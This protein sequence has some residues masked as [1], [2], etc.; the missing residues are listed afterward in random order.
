MGTAVSRARGNGILSAV[1]VGAFFGILPA[2]ILLA[3]PL[4]PFRWY[5]FAVL[6]LGAV[7]LVLVFRNNRL[8]H[9]G[10]L[11]FSLCLNLDIHIVTLP[12]VSYQSLYGYVIPLTLFPLI[13]LYIRRI[14]EF[15]ADKERREP[16]KRAMLPLVIFAAFCLFSIF[17]SG[18][19]EHTRYELFALAQSL[20]IYYYLAGNIRNRKEVRVIVYALI[21]GVALQAVLATLQ[22]LTGS[23]LGLGMF[24]ESERQFGE[25]VSLLSITRV[26]GTMG[27]PNSLAIYLEFL[28]PVS[29]AA[30]LTSRAGPKRWLLMGIAAFG[31][32]ALIFTLS[33]AGLLV[34]VFS[35][36]TVLLVWGKRNRRLG[37]VL[38]A[39][40]ACLAIGMAIFSLVENPIKARFFK[41]R[42]QAAYSRLPMMSV[43]FRM[44]EDN[45]LFGVG[46]NTYTWVA[47]RYDFTTE[48]I[49]L[50]FPMPVHNM[51]L[52]MLA[53]IGIF[54]FLAFIVFMIT[55]LTKG[56]KVARAADKEMALIGLGI[57][58]GILA[59]SIHGMVDLN[60]ISKNFTF[61]LLAGTLVGIWNLLRR[62]PVSAGLPNHT[63]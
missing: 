61:W 8:F 52:L 57:T 14:W 44:I 62:K 63:E 22:Y 51:Y 35:L 56:L 60:H 43:A 12:M 36:I 59:F 24:G 23:Y 11:A 53:E 9:I 5:L 1:L 46:L 33:R 50:I 47:P 15:W 38:A 7:A 31:V 3:T 18:S 2:A 4:L 26:S 32:L 49:S 37:F 48:K 39:I 20:L 41:D 34:S 6:L 58:M 45:F 16:M 13:F 17:P 54:G 10:L 19:P 25:M 30:A 40:L 42:Y 28:L 29:L 27:H 55:L 21:A